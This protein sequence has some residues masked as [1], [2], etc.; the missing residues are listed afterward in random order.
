MKKITCFFM[1]MCMLFYFA[2]VSLAAPNEDIISIKEYE[3]AVKMVGEEYG[4][5]LF[6]LDYNPSV[7]ITKEIL[8]YEMDDLRLTL[9]MAK[10][11]KKQTNLFS[12]KKISIFPDSPQRVMPVTRY[13][14]NSFTVS[15][16]LVNGQAVFL[17]SA[18]VTTDAQNYY[19]ISVNSITA[20][21]VGN[22]TNFDGW[23][24][25]SISTTRNSPSQGYIT[26][27]VRGRATFSKTGSISGN[28][29]GRTET[30]NETVVINCRG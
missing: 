6:L 16:P 3:A 24:T 1:S 19:V 23:I 5:E 4:I 13:F 11:V 22:F 20:H 27:T 15:C 17:V 30:V 2:T 28:K 18:N 10:P 29:I 26:A 9:Q 7:Q 21:Q 8:A 25:D 14:S 12:N